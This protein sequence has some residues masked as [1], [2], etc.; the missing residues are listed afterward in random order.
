LFSL[1][2]FDKKGYM[3]SNLLWV[4]LTFNPHLCSLKEAWEKIGYYWNLWITNMRNKY[5]KISYFETPEAFPNPEGS[6]YGYPHIHVALLFE[7]HTF[8]AF[9]NWE[10]GRDGSEGWSFRI[11]ERNEIKQQGKWMAHVDIKAIQSGRALGGYLRKHMKNTQGGNDPAALTTQALLW[12]HRKKT[13]TMSKGFRQKFN[14]LITG[15]N[16][17]KTSVMQET[18]DG[19]EI[20]VWIWSFHGIC[21]FRD[22]D[23][24]PG[25]WVKELDKKKFRDLK[26][27]A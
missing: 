20:P 27:I 11:L 15:K 7:E 4:T 1:E 14:D 26:T 21:N 6:A 16:N 10:K 2:D 3:P 5:G 13:Y 24:D 19:K 12:I 18:L 17:S 22:L 23:V 25:V 9:P 8:N